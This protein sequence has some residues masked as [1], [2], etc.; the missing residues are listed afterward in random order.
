M[1]VETQVHQGLAGTGSYRPVFAIFEGGGAKGISHIGALKALEHEQLAIAGVAGSSAGAIIAAFVA[2]GFSASDM[3]DAKKRTDILRTH[4]RGSPIDVLGRGS[5]RRF[6]MIRRFAMPL[7]AM[8]GATVIVA[9][10]LML[11]HHPVWIAFA[12][13]GVGLACIVSVAALVWPVLTRHGLF[14][15]TRLQAILN[16]I[17]L[18][19]LNAH[20]KARG[21][22]SKPAG[23]RVTFADI[24]PA[25]VPECA[26]LKIIVSNVGSGTL[27]VFDQSTPKVVLAQAVAASASIPFAF[28]PPAIEGAKADA[29][30]TPIY[31]DGGLLSNLPVWSL[32]AEKRA[33]ER[34]QGGPQVPIIAFSLDDSSVVGRRGGSPSLRRWLIACT[35][36]PYLVKVVQ[37]GIFGSQQVVQRFV[38]DLVTIALDSTLDTMRF[39]CDREAA[40]AAFNAGFTSA[41]TK[42]LELRRIAD[43]TS[44][45]LGSILA[46][47]ESVVAAQRATQHAAIPKIRVSL[48]D[49]IDPFDTR[50]TAF[51]VVA[52]VGMTLDA[53]DQLELDNKNR[54]APQA[55]KL[56]I[57]QFDV[58]LDMLARD[59]TMT[60]YEFALLCPRVHSVI[61]IPIFAPSPGNTEPERVLCIDSTDSL[62]DIF[63]D[64]VIMEALRGRA[65]LASRALIR[66][67][68]GVF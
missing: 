40:G 38:P 57:A 19:K 58:V 7:I 48:I 21:E 47:V 20:L 15:S 52:S 68:T 39:D 33:L 1:D 55:F 17:F 61:S 37:T 27:E 46:H 63:K 51:R 32:S 43:I 11:T 56:G 67:S 42:L 8:A 45:V 16:A 65:V 13:L 54:I 6:G 34:R 23:H 28:R 31:V 59:L 4:E 2:L 49:P 14:D 30:V 3:F 29:A 26:T 18:Q 60:K 12:A 62:E 36:L 24:D 64:L 53:D 22:P 50:N 44:M 41:T 10:G 9:F 5:W 35:P 66:R 25:R